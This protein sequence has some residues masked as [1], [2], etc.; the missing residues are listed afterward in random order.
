MHEQR[1]RTAEKL[2]H[3]VRARGGIRRGGEGDRL[4]A[5]ECGLNLVEL[6]VFGAEVVAP[7][8]D[9][10]GLIDR[11]HR[12]L[13][14]LEQIERFGFQQ[15]LRRHVDETQLAAR[16]ALEDRRGSRPGSLAELS[17]AAATS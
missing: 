16:D 15:P 9:A 12:D 6:G 10:M 14:A 3:N 8:R 17:A 1:R 11:Q 7:L 2:C 5:A 13:G 4:H